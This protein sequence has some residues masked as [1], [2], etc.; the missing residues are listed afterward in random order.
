MNYLER[1]P[2]VLHQNCKGGKWDRENKIREA[3]SECVHLAGQ[4][5]K[6]ARIG[7][8]WRMEEAFGSSNEATREHVISVFSEA[9]RKC[10]QDLHKVDQ[11]CPEYYGEYT[12]A[13]QL[14]RLNATKSPA[15][16]KSILFNPGGP[17]E[18]GIEHTPTTGQDIHD[19][20]GRTIPFSCR[21]NN[22]LARRED[23][24]DELAWPM[25]DTWPSFKEQGWANVG[26]IADQCFNLQQKYGR[27]IGTVATARDMLAIVNA[28]GEDGQL[29]YWG[30]SYGTMLGQVFASMFPGRVNRMVLDGNVMIDDYVSDAGIKSFRNSNKAFHHFLDQCYQ[31]PKFSQLREAI[32]DAFKNMLGVES[33][34]PNEVLDPQNLNR[35]GLERFLKAKKHIL[36]GLHSVDGFLTVLHTIKESILPY[37]TKRELP[38]LQ[39]QEGLRGSSPP[40]NQGLDAQVGIHC[41]DS[42]DLR[43]DIPEDLYAIIR[44]HTAQSSFGDIGGPPELKCARWKF[45]AIEQVNTTLLRKV[46]TSFPILITNGKYDP[47]TPLDSAWE[48]SHRLRGSRVLVH[49]GVGHSVIQ[50]PSKCTYQFIRDYF[51]DG[52]MPELGTVCKADTPPFKLAYERLFKR[53]KNKEN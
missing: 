40:W 29:R 6:A 32:N 14:V 46:T 23:E 49:D 25:V 9:E 3:L 2:K 47:I 17:G 31:E 16:A 18:S 51:T 34:D 53:Y 11:I 5:K 35:S 8:A 52:T 36:K 48:V 38:E 21:S 33:L 19:G 20:T 50:H 44:A 4:G 42:S 45:D 13:L 12:I 26:H 41:S 24:L 15:K 1:M 30:I 28:L 37:K 27:Y 7:P 43:V 22:N 10:M 39:E